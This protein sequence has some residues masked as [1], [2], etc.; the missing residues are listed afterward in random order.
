VRRRTGK[1]AENDEEEFEM[2]SRQAARRK[3][4]RDISSKHNTAA[5][6]PNVEQ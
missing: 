1:G 6:A 4:D 3:A 5:L 2:T